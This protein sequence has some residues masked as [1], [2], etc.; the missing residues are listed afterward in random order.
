MNHISKSFAS[1][2]GRVFKSHSWELREGGYRRIAM[3]IGNGLWPVAQDTRLI[4]FLLDRGF[5]VLALDLAFGAPSTPR[6]GLRAFREAFS[7]F[8][9]SSAEPGMPVYLVASSFSAGAI[10]PVASSIPGLAAVSLLAPVVDFPPPRL[11]KAFFFRGAELP[12]L[13]EDLCGDSRLA[14]SLK[15]QPSMMKFRK[16]DLK[17]AAADLG[18]TLGSRFAL[19]LAAFSGE[20]D[21][22]ITQEGRAALGRSG[23]K[24]YAYPRVGHEPGRDR[25]SDNFYADLGSFIDEVES[26]GGKAGT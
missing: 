9:R 14:E 11:K 8:A 4:L 1:T 6:L 7:A 16:R 10:L 2:D 22:F 23:A 13:P 21:P 19:P 18:S 25:Y 12:I 20:E 17:T 26:R 3:L 5:R 24:L 15:L